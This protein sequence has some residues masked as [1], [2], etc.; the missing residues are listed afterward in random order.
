MKCGYLSQYFER[1]A[2]KSLV[3]V[4]AGGRSNQHEFNGVGILKK[5]FGTQTG[6]KRIGARF[7]YLNDESMVADDGTLTWY[8]SREN[9]P[10][11]SEWRLY[12]TSNDV[13]GIMRKDDTLFICLRADGTVLVIIAQNGTTI[14][15]QLKW[16]F[17]IRDDIL[18]R[19]R[20]KEDFELDKSKVL[21]TSRL[22][23]EQI[24]VESL[25][26]TDNCLEEML[27]RFGGSFP[28]TKEFSAFAREMAGPGSPVEE[29][30]ETLLLWVEREEAL[31][32][33]LEKHII[34]ERLKKGF[35]EYGEVDVDG[36]VKFSL[37]VQNRRKSRVGQALE[38]HIEAIFLENRILYDRTPVTEN[39]S[40]P[41]FILPGIAAYQDPFFPEENLT[42]LGVKST[43]KDR[44]RQVLDEADR[45]EKKHLLTLEAAISEN[46]TDAMQKRK[47]QLV[48]PLELH[49]TYH[50]RQ[51]RWLYSV[52]DFIREVKEKQEKEEHVKRIQN[53]RGL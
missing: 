11:R 12:Y 4:E 50:E 18:D 51:R 36:F 6:K 35:I 17:D 29:P 23:L 30:D 5:L 10:G 9:I 41:D 15:N 53:K 37:S 49:E 26:D 25:E 32:R 42:M 20:V 3:D 47:L 2:V 44:W 46:Q 1:V 16:L 34:S 27:E 8:D 52:K 48:L 39:K 24:G 33:T 28:S 19:F 7:V 40:K 31:F 13:T 22:I 14:E 21:F 38:N 43:C 45:I